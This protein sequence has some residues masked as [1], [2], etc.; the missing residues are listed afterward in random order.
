MTRKL[1]ILPALLLPLAFLVGLPPSTAAP[2]GNL[3]GAIFTSDGTGVPVNLNHYAAKTDV[4]LNGGPGLNAPDSAAG[5]PAGTYSFQVTDPNGKTLL[6]E[7]NVSC[8]QVVV[9][10]S[11]VF[12]AVL[13]G[14]ECTTGAHALGADGEDGGITVQLFPFADTP[15]NGGEY[16]V[17]LTP[18]SSLNC[19]SG[20][21]RHCF[22]PRYSKTD[23]FKVRANAIVEIDTRFWKDGSSTPLLGMEAGWTDTN[24]ASNVKFSEY[25]PSLLAYWEAHVEAAEA[26]S[27]RITVEDQ[28]GCTIDHVTGPRGENYRSG[29]GRY[30]I[31]VDVADSRPGD[32]TTYRVEVFCK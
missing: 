27:H 9:D 29:S 10:A 13:A 12:T 21:N 30:N 19:S 17:W 22:V 31:R 23:N 5:L 20:G 15:N 7:D 26:G 14:P 25:D 2:G 32:N 11:G 18:T 3:S 6:S 24:G 4:H 8:R 1:R 28:P 16:K